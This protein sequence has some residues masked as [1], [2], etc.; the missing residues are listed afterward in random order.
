[1]PTVGSVDKSFVFDG[2]T[3][4]ASDGRVT[5]AAGTLAG[6]DLDMLTAVNNAAVFADLDWFEAVRMATV[7]PARALGLQEELGAIGP[8]YRA[9]LLAFDAQRHIRASWI[10]GVR[11]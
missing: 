2:E 9:S 5:T 6:S 7:Y 11:A 8:G 4:T 1:M 3:I 10:D